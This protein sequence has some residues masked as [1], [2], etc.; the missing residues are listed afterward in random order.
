MD[1]NHQIEI[2]MKMKSTLE[3]VGGAILKRIIMVL[4]REIIDV[5]IHAKDTNKI[6]LTGDLV[7]DLGH[8]HVVAHVR[9][10]EDPIQDQDN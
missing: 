4:R 7:L 2:G 8:H 6:K 5:G 3:I 10:I 1:V 9:P